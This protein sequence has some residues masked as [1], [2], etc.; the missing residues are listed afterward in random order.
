MD[1]LFFCRGFRWGSEWG[2]KGEE[3]VRTCF[4]INI[5][6]HTRSSVL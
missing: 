2:E 4:R 3:F 5:F 6:F 1:E